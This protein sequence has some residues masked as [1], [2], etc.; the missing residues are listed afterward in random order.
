MRDCI[1]RTVKIYETPLSILKIDKEGKPNLTELPKRVSA[2]YPNEKKIREQYPLNKGETLIIGETET[3]E[4]RLKM[5]IDFFI[6]NSEEI[7]DDEQETV[8]E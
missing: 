4:K 6:A 5:S 3:K 8:T 2:S 7:T 1:T